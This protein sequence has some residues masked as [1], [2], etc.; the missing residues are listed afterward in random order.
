MNSP[1]AKI[2]TF[3]LD[4]SLR[5]SKPWENSTTPTSST[6]LTMAWRLA[7]M[8]FRESKTSMNTR[9]G[10]PLLPKAPASKLDHASEEMSTCLMSLQRSVTSPALTLLERMKGSAF[11]LF[12]KGSQ[13][14]FVTFSMA[15]IVVAQSQ[16]FE[17]YE[18]GIG[19]SSNMNLQKM[20]FRRHNFSIL[21]KTRMNCFW[22]TTK[23]PSQG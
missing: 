10:F 15:R 8:A 23:M 22:S 14:Q 5:D 12:W 6:Q 20:V 2:L 3:R 18:A 19:N 4:V 7:D 21:P 16:A 11:A 9:G 17:P 1:A 13:T